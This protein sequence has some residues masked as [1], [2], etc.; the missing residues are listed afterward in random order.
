M[1]RDV[2]QLSYLRIVLKQNVYECILSP[3]KNH[4]NS[5]LR[6]SCQKRHYLHGF[7]SFASYKLKHLCVLKVIFLYAPC[8]SHIHLHFGPVIQIYPLKLVLHFNNLGLLRILNSCFFKVFGICPVRS[9]CL[10]PSSFNDKY[11]GLFI[12]LGI[13]CVGKTIV[14]ELD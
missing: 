11:L 9:S 14:L 2:K 6:S 3:F 12:W 5:V 1:F 8:Y 7:V 13:V 10:A 4:F